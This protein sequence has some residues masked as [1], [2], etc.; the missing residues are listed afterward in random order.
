M[1]DLPT[2]QQ[3]ISGRP[4]LNKNEVELMVFND[5]S[6]NIYPSNKK[7]FMRFTTHRI[8][9]HLKDSEMNRFIPIEK[10]INFVEVSVEENT[11]MFGWFKK[12]KV[13]GVN[14]DLLFKRE[15]DEEVNVTVEIVFSTEEDSVN[16]LKTFPGVLQDK[17]NEDIK[18]SEKKQFSIANTGVGGL[19]KKREDTHKQTEEDMEIA[20]QDIKALMEKAKK[21]VAIA[22]KLNAKSK[23]KDDADVN[24]LINNFGITSVVMKNNSGDLFHTELSRQLTDFLITPLH[25]NGGILSLTD[26]YCL[27]N[28]ARGTSLVSPKDVLIACEL[29]EE[30]GLPLTLK[31][32]SS[33]L[34]VVQSSEYTEESMT[35][36]IEELIVGKEFPMT[37]VDFASK[38]K[39]P[40]LL[41]NHILQKAEDE[42]M[43][44]IDDSFEGTI[45]YPNIFNTYYFN[46]I[47]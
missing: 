10:V 24:E 35:D 27:Y 19:I 29:F 25:E 39:M 26:V 31:K 16:F 7:S 21:M 36:K 12:R 34:L 45:Y 44:C 3:E 2:F 47:Q 14:M 15:N 9:F 43:L 13:I 1:D 11:G 23:G 5:V 46:L 41:A 4:V 22:E 40:L 42:E 30:L 8:F 38:M 37:A 32:Y 17:I 18:K 28:R 20:F 6:V 33:G